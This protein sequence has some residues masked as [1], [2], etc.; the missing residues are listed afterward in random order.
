MRAGRSRAPRSQGRNASAR[1]FTPSILPECHDFAMGT[2]R[3]E[4]FSD[5]VFAVAI[6]LL[7]FNLSVPGPG[8]HEPSLAAQLGAHWP[9]FAGYVVSFATIGIIWVNHHTMFKN[10]AAVDRVRIASRLGASTLFEAM[11]LDSAG[12]R[13]L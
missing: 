4:A 1:S 8:R 9:A 12:S 13:A 11:C 7:V 5:G 2:S 3:L 6:T 10:F